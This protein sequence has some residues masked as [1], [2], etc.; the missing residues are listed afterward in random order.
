MICNDVIMVV[1]VVV[2]D[3]IIF[4]FG[5]GLLEEVGIMFELIK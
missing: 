5:L 2:Y 4:F 1:E 3:V